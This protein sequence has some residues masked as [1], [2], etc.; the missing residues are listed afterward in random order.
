MPE[1]LEERT[2]TIFVD[3]SMR[4]SPRRGGIGIRFVWITGN[5]QESEPWDHALPATEGATNQQMELEAPYQAVK[6]AVSRH[7]PFSLADFDKIEIRTDSEYVK[8]GVGRAINYW[9]KDK[10]VTR[11][12]SAVL[13]VRDWKDLLRMMRRCWEGHRLPVKFEWK[14]GKRGKHALAVDELAKQSSAGPSFGRERP[15][16]VRRKTTT[17][18][19]EIGSVVMEGQVMTVRIVQAQY[20]PPPHRRSRYKY[21]VADDASPYRG[22][23]DWAE[24]S[25]EL[26]RGHTYSVRVNEPPENPRFIELLEEIEEDL[27]PYIGALKVLGRASSAQEVVDELRRSFDA[28]PSR[29]AVRRRLDR[30]VEEGKVTRSRASTSGRP[31]VYEVVD[32]TSV[33]AG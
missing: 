31:Y 18:H 22:K 21:E 11:E 24:S 32:A 29:E 8:D 17:E 15:N 16:I 13:N 9:S 14:Q 5:G 4:S 28:A 7:A 23:V 12:G 26:K 2:L 20:L 6:L 25:L 33:E 27:T 10:W 19:V 3:G 1:P 30:L